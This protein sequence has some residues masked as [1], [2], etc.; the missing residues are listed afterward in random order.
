MKKP[1]VVFAI[2]VVLALLV[3]AVVRAQMSRELILQRDGLPLVNLKVGIMPAGVMGSTTIPTSTDPDGKLD[4]SGVPWGAE[5]I[6]V[7]LSDGTNTVVRNTLFTLPK[8]GSLTI[9]FRGTRTIRTTTKIYA[10][11]ILFKLT[12]QEVGIYEEI[13]SPGPV[14]PEITPT[15]EPIPQTQT[16]NDTAE[17]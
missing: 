12:T 8:S 14:I 16:D 3:L 6:N 9:D 15:P 17:K 4:L 11:F 13:G 10:D 5:Y 7:E 2:L 1:L